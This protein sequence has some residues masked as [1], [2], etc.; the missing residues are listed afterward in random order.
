MN[1]LVPSERGWMAQKL[2]FAGD[3]G[4]TETLADQHPLCAL[5][6]LHKGEATR[7][8]PLGKSQAMALLVAASPHVN[9]DP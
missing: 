1:P 7:V 5:C 2:P 3:P 4:P 8:A 6:Q 9:A